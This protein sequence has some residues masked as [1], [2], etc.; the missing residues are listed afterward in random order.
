MG[1]PDFY[2]IGA[3]KAGTSWLSKMLEQHPDVNLGAFKESHYFNSL[4]IKKDSRWTS[5]YVRRNVARIIHTLTA[6]KD[7]DYTQLRNILD[8]ADCNKMFTEDWYH[9]YFDS[10]GGKGTRGDFTP[11]YSALPREGIEHVKKLTPDAKI[12]YIIRDPV[13]RA[14]SQIRM[15][16]SRGQVM[17]SYEDLLKGDVFN[18]GD[19]LNNVKL[20]DEYFSDIFYVPY[21]DI[22]L[23][24]AK[25]LSEIESYIGLEAYS[26]KGVAEKVHKGK[27]IDLD[28]N[29]INM[30]TKEMN[31][32]Y[33]FIAD[34]FGEDFVSRI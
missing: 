6:K 24:P 16:I 13:N 27:K 17:S 10:V 2:C 14:L 34:R 32:Q 22:H 26:Y 29:I 7:L 25:L 8:L 19:Y 18:R 20:W 15:N 33:D 3:Q 28:R 21:K 1:L 11:A 31:P 4:Y 23:S 30:I 12:I 5:G 9:L